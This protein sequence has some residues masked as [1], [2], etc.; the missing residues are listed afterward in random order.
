MASLGK[1]RGDFEV[2]VVNNDSGEDLGWVE[3]AAVLDAGGNV[4]FS[5]G[6]TLGAVR[7]SGEIL[8]F[9]NPDTTVDQDWLVA[10]EKVF[11]DPEVGAVQSFLLQLD[12]PTRIDCAGG[13]ADLWGWARKG[14]YNRKLAEV[15]LEDTKPIFYA[16]GAAV[17]VRRS[18]FE[19][20][21]GFDEGMA[22]YHEDVDLGWRVWLAGFKVVLAA[23]SWVYH[24]GGGSRVDGDEFPVIY[25]RERNKIVTVFKNYSR[26]NLIWILPLLYFL[27]LVSF[28]YFVVVD[29]NIS[30]GWAHLKAVLW[31]FLNLRYFATKRREVQRTRRVP[32]R[33]IMKL[34]QKWPMV[35]GLAFAR[36]GK[37]PHSLTLRV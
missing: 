37:P 22:L 4:G 23:G 26:L 7:A 8:V 3:G 15:R 27:Q 30:K 20:I 6:N 11:S 24:K 9:L 18:V 10:L 5:R 33:V 2:V 36:R 16:M 32:D 28:M 17:A 35:I 25:S 29:R 31:S 1:R 19:Q 34:L 13:V 21:G 14:E 12:D